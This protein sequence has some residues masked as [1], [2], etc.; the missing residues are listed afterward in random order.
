MNSARSSLQGFQRTAGGITGAMRG[1]TSSF[2]GMV[3]TGG[4][5][6]AFANQVRTGVREAIEFESAFANVR[7]TVNASEQDFASL[8]MELTQLSVTTGESATELFRAAGAA[9]QIGIRTENIARFT[10]VM[11]EMAIASNLTSDE[12]AIGFSK[13]ALVT[14]LA[15]EKIENLTSSVV[16]LGNSSGANEGEILDT[17]LRFAAMAKNAKM[18]DSEI[19]AL[20]ASLI[21]VGMAP[22]AGGTAMSRIITDIGKAAATGGKELEMFAA[23]AGQSSA[24][25]QQAFGANAT[26]AILSVAAGLNRF[27]EAG[28]NTYLLLEKLGM[29]DI[30]ISQAML[31]LANANEKVTENIRNSAT[32][33]EENNARSKEA[34]ERYKTTEYQI[35]QMNNSLTA[36]RVE[37]AGELMDSM[38]GTIGNIKGISEAL[39]GMN[40]A[41][42]PIGGILGTL[43]QVMSSSLSARKAELYLFAGAFVT[44]FQKI[45]GVVMIA[46]SN[47]IGAIKQFRDFF[48]T[49]EIGAIMTSLTGVNID[50]FAGMDFEKG[51]KSFFD[52][53]MEMLKGGGAMGDFANDLFSKSGDAYNESIDKYKDI[54]RALVKGIFTGNEAGKPQAEAAGAAAGDSFAYKFT[55]AMIARFSGKD[56]AF[57][58]GINALMGGEQGVDKNGF[59][60]KITEALMDMFG[61]K[62]QKESEAG[63]LLPT[64]QKE[65]G[66]QEGITGEM[67]EQAKLSKDAGQGTAMRAGEFAQNVGRIFGGTGATATGGTANA[68]P[69]SFAARS[70]MAAGDA[71]TGADASIPLLQGILDA[72]KQIV[73]NTMRPAVAVAG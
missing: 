38:T 31:G 3:G 39:R 1:L 5:L 70:A 6:L 17:S 43:M 60:Y 28:G 32:A 27:S 29:E 20:A 58:S 63:R 59:G 35:K 68:S 62:S 66:Y 71:R 13:W 67:E 64:L 12:A 54:G 40:S 37:M 22:E 52:N 57:V 14:G 33:F 47:I 4:A 50:P 36:L 23:L 69:T 9:G 53:G 19:A 46:I 2:A 48:W 45:Q 49:D 24:E 61:S 21:S 8:R 55:E 72:S 16:A 7:K 56:N 11:S 41:L 18:A 34:A 15:Q 73:T 25:F 10:E 30:R 42:K 65:L 51:Q 26:N 44:V